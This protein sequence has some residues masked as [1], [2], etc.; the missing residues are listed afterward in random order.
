[1]WRWPPRPAVAA[2]FSGLCPIRQF[3]VT[4]DYSQ[5]LQACGPSFAEKHKQEYRALEPELEN[6]RDAFA[7]LTTEATRDEEITRDFNWALQDF[8]D[9]RG[10]WDEKIR[11]QLRAGEACQRMDDK[12]G[13][14]TTYN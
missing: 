6:L 11:W 5:M 2:K 13:L 10:Y 9:R 12:R 1:M 8:F 14:A 3:I 4:G 7:F